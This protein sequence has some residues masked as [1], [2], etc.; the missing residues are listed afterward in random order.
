LNLFSQLRDKTNIVL[1]SVFSKE[2]LSFMRE[3]REKYKT[4]ERKKWLVLG[5]ESWIKGA[6]EA[7]LWCAA[8][9]KDYEVVW[10]VPYKQLLE[11][12]AQA[13]GFVY[14]PK[15]K[16]TCPRM[17]IEAKLLGCQLYL[18]DNVQHKDEDWFNSPLEEIEE[19]LFAAHSVFWNAI[20][21]HMDYKPSV[22][23][24]TTTY[25]CVSQQY[26]FEQ[27]I[28]SLLQFCDEV[29]VVDGGSTDGTLEVLE[30]L[31][32]EDVRLKYKVISRDWND[33]KSAVFDGLQKAEARLMCTKEYCWQMD[34]DEIFH[35]T[36]VEKVRI[37]CRSL[38]KE[39]D[40]IALP[41]V[42]YWGSYDKVRVDVNPWKWRLSRNRP[43]ITHGIPVELRKYDEEGNLYASEGTDGCDMIDSSTGQRLPFLSFYTGAVDGTRMAALSGDMKANQAYENWFNSA[44]TE[45]PAVYHY[46]WFN[47]VR[48][49]H[50]YKNFWTRHWITLLGKDYVDSAETNMMFDVPWSEVTDEMIEQRA[51]ELSTNTG[52][53][54][55]HRK[56]DGTR[57]PHIKCHKSPPAVMKEWK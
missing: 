8:T 5:S 49:I 6:D 43:H 48:K 44:I 19:Y 35:E 55:W 32:A 29:C 24:Y 17:V 4:T 1:S 50:T 54:I 25:N 36:D 2:S 14:L 47:M 46:S 21:T 11:R 39:V 20:K 23:G 33:P 26:P 52:G 16:D 56:F 3:L 15:G 30:K 10:N 7:Q 38:S 28:R 13:E 37:I 22:S 40:V 18:N 42:E 41:V 34:S 27:S 53:W 57:R 9:G 12:M 31:S 45:L 51:K